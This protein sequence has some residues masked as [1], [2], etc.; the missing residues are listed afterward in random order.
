MM[1]DQQIL[2]P[3]L[4]LYFDPEIATFYR[5]KQVLNAFFQVYSFICSANKLSL[6]KVIDL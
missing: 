6:A 5:L 1:F 2:L 3:L 4:L